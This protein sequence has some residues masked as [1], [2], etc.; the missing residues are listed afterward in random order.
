MLLLVLQALRQA[1]VCCK[2]SKQ[3]CVVR[4]CLEPQHKL[5]LKKMIYF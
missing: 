1:S 4:F 2:F 5:Y 3:E